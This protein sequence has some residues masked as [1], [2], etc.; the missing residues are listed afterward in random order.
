MQKILTVLQHDE[1]YPRPEMLVTFFGNHDNMRFMSE[2]DSSPQKLKAAFSLLLTMRGIPQIYA[3]D[4]IAMDGGTDP[5]NRHDFPGGFP[6]D[7][8][9]VF[10]AAGRTREQQDVYSLVQNLIALR[11]NHPAL[12]TG[13]QWHIGWDDSYYAF[14]RELPEEKIFVVYN[15]APK[16]R[17]LEIPIADTPM[18]NARELQPIFGGV[19]ASIRAGQARLSL[20]ARSIAVFTVY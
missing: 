15:N 5:D 6:G 19:T 16:T 20:P 18:E 2:K 17:A 1:L 8:R 3:G 11:K 9:D 7:A 4:E 10:T 13:T 14:L 12:R